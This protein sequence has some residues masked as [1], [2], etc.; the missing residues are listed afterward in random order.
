ML[1]A[2]ANDLVNRPFLYITRGLACLTGATL[3][4]SI[5]GSLKLESSGVGLLVRGEHFV[6]VASKQQGVIQKQFFKLNQQVKVGDILV[7]LETDN[8]QLQLDASDQTLGLSKPLTQLSLEAGQQ[9]A[10]LSLANISDA[11]QILRRNINALK[12]VIS[13]QQKAYD[14][15]LGLYFSNLASSSEL[16]SSYSS[17]LQLKQQLLE[18]QRGVRQQQINYQQLLQ[19]NA[20]SS[21]DLSSQNIATGANAAETKLQISQSREIRAP[22]DGTIISY[23]IPVGGFVNPGDPVITLVPSTGPLRALILVGSDQFGRIKTGDQALI[24]PSESPS[25]RFGFMKGKV[26][27]K[28]IAPATSAELLKAFGS[29]DVVQTLQSSFNTGNQSGSLPYLVDIQIDEKYNKP[30]WTL[31]QQPPWGVNPGRGLTAR[32][33]TEKVAPISLLIPFLRGL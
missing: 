31:G 32:V 24:S 23:N 11:Q 10:S 13:Q 30:V 7:S 19:A 29:Q 2:R 14:G 1:E 17:L 4:W 8:S 33:I 28:S 25:I 22:I 21:I 26:H 6:T 16:A 12:N 9:A 5:F 15:V 3:L 20:Q 27:S 18:L